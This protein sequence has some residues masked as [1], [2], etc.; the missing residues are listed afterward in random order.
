MVKY[1]FTFL[2]VCLYIL[3]REHSGY[4]TFVVLEVL[5]DGK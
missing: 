3:Q 1:Q 5:E 4:V 2:R